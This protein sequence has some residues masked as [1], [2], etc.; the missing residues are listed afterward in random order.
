MHIKVTGIEI[1]YD[2]RQYVYK[3]QEPESFTGFAV[4]FEV[5]FLQNDAYQY[6]YKYGTVPK[7]SAG[8]RHNVLA[9]QKDHGYQEEVE[10]DG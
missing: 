9:C 1:K 10:E 2:G 6:P 3:E 7:P 8:C 4:A 5:E